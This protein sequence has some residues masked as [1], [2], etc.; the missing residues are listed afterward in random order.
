MKAYMGR[1]YSIQ[2]KIR[3]NTLNHNSYVNHP[4]S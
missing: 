1:C 3:S 2:N 4:L